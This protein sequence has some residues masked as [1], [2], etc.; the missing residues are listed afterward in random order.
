MGAKKQAAK[1]G[2]GVWAASR[3]V[4]HNPYL[5]RMLDDDDLRE[6]LREAFES[7]RRAYARMS[8][9]KGPAHAV[10]D[11][12][13]TQKE[14]KRAAGNLSEAADTLRGVRKGHKR[15]RR[16]GLILLLLVGA[17]AAL[18]LSEELRKKVL[19]LIFGAEEEFEYTSTT[20]PPPPPASSS[21]SDTPEGPGVGTS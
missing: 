15:R 19:D 17:G 4:Q 16:G 11:D 3:A 8:N 9:G 21:T 6:N 12:R 10:L 18:A 5:Q 14:L 20:A 7:T 13:K 2:A 1:A